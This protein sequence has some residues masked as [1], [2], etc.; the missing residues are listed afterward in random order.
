MKAIAL[1][2]I[3]LANGCI[4][5]LPAIQNTFIFYLDI[6]VI[7]LLLLLCLDFISKLP[8]NVTFLKSLAMGSLFFCLLCLVIISRG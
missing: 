4:Y 6:G 5:S 7:M 3:I 2:L 8:S 1:I